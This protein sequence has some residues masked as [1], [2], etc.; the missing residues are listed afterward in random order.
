MKKTFLALSLVAILAACNGSGSNG[1]PVVSDST[2]VS[3]S[4]KVTS[5]TTVVEAVDS[6]K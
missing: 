6:L 5:D 4:L 2:Q 1:T 3:D